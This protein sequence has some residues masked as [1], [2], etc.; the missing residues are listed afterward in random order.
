MQPAKHLVIWNFDVFSYNCL[1]FLAIITYKYIRL[2][3]EVM[4]SVN[5][6]LCAYFVISLLLLLTYNEVINFFL[7]LYL[8]VITSIIRLTWHYFW[9]WNPVTQMLPSQ[10][11]IQ[12]TKSHRIPWIMWMTYTR[13]PI[14]CNIEFVDPCC[15]MHLDLFAEHTNPFFA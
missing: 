7:I 2:T 12:W 3:W 1:M 13:F 11:A 4:A 14:K 15:K 6:M 9:F 5:C 10:S 8:L